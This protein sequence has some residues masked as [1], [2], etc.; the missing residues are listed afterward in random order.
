[1]DR[2]YVVTGAASGIGAATA[3]LLAGQGATVITSDL[4]DA[5]VIANLATA[6]GRGALVEGVRDRSG[7][8]I[9]AIVAN[10]GGGPA[11]TMLALNF[12]GA[13]A[14]LEGL[15]PLLAASPAP[16]AV[17]VSSVASLRPPP[18]GLVEACLAL[19]EGA[20]IAAAPPAHDVQTGLDLYGAAK[21]ALQLW[22]RRQAAGPDWAAA[23]IPLNVV[24][25]G[26]YDTPAAAYVLTDPES[27]AAM[28]EL[29]PLSGAFPG[30]PEE[31]A[32]LL[33]WCVSPENSQMTG[34]ILYADAGIECRGRPERAA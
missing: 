20:A 14:T 30:R 26:F 13:V 17:A 10:A 27:R 32:A 25:L 5:D 23:G 34:Q 19:D 33:A 11:A 21:R 18:A 2:T 9:D 31:A 6:E 24:A 15:R 1:M 29:A 22:C 7:G 8:R 28:A 16:R 4:H 12:F 3:R